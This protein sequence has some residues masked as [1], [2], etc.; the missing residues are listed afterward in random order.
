PGFG[1]KHHP[2]EG[3]WESTWLFSYYA[4]YLQGGGGDAWGVAMANVS[5]HRYGP[6]PG[7]I[8]KQ[9]EPPSEAVL[10]EKGYLLPNGTVNPD[11]TFLLYYLGDYDLVHPTQ[12]AWADWERTTWIDSGRGQIPLAWGINPGMEEEIPAIMSYMLATRTEYDYLVAS[13]SGA[14]Y[15]NPQGLSRRYRQQWLTRSGDYYQ[16]YDIQI[17]GF[18]LNGRGND[19]PLEWVNRFTSIAPNGIIAP[20]F[21]LVTHWP[22]LLNETPFTGMARETV[23]DHIQGSANVIHT[24]YQRNLAQGRP[25]FLAIRSSFQQPVFLHHV[26]N[27]IRSDD[28]QGVIIAENGDVLHPNYTLVDPYTFFALLKVWLQTKWLETTP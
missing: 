14:G 28:E 27:Q 15:L 13:N 16:K 7:A 18:L 8:T 23:G 6:K 12:V 3:E 20:E 1:G 25:P 22:I 26:Y 5:V 2:V 4:G 10:A 11:L 19:L 21:E 17:Q 9:P 24:V